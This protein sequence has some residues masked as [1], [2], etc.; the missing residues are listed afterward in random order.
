MEEHRLKV[1]E[2]R[3][4]RRNFGARRMEERGSWRKFHNKEL[5]L[6]PST[7]YSDDQIK[8]QM[9]TARNMRRRKKK[10]VHSFG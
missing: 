10:Y 4:L 3:V 2:N 1:F 5:N 9:G 6:H 8:E 7:G